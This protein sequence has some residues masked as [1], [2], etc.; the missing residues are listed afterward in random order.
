MQS[1]SGLRIVYFTCSRKPSRVD[2][3]QYDELH[4]YWLAQN[5][6]KDPAAAYRHYVKAGRNESENPLTA[7]LSGWVLGSESFLKKA[8]ALAQSD[9]DQKRQRTSRRLKAVTADQIIVETAA[10]HDVCPAEY[11]GFRSVAVGHEV[12]ALLSRAW[13]RVRGSILVK[14]GPCSS[15]I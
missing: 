4:T 5:G 8:I 11:V 2:W 15:I 13:S 6:G 12:A 10:Y 1:L 14:H 9:D 7:A 3:V